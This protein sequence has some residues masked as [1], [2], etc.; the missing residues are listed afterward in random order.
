MLTAVVALVVTLTGFGET[1][2]NV[3]GSQ[4]PNSNL[5]DIYYDLNATDGGTFTVEVAVEGRTNDV[6]ATTFS[7][8]IGKG[9]APGKNRHIV[10][11][12]GADWRNNKGD[13]KAVVTAAIEVPK[14]KPKKIQLWE[15][16]PYWADRNIGADNPW[17]AG[18]YFWWGDTTGH[19]PSGTTFDFFFDYSNCPTYRKYSATLQSEGWITA[20]GVLAPE[21]DAAHVYWGGW[22]RMPTDQELHALS[23]NCDWTWTAMNGVNG[24]VVRGRGTY[25]SNSIF[26][27]LP[28]FGNGFSLNKNS[29]SYYW[30]SEPCSDLGSSRTL[31][32]SSPGNGNPSFTGGNV[33]IDGS[34]IR[35]VQGFAE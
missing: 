17:E 15:G 34:P 29:L 9:I 8:D 28:G 3:R 27:P 18:L 22:W 23:I 13:V 14:G 20:D 10:W 7:G 30:S 35:P 25:A 2:E 33:R 19:R 4:R 26:F 6:T 31:N 1:V 11:E 16:G 12:A 21:H 32:I 24:Y 5:V